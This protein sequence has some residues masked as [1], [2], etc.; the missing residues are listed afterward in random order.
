VDTLCPSRSHAAA[1]SQAPHLQVESLTVE[2]GGRVLVR[3]L[4]LEVPRGRFVAVIGPSGAGKSTLLETLAGMRPHH[5]GAITY[6]CE[7]QC[8]HA[9]CDFRSRI[10]LVFQQLHLARNAS[11]LQ[12]VLA[13]ALPRHPWWR[14]LAGFPAS[15]RS[16]AHRCLDSLG[17]GPLRYRLVRRLSGGEQQRVAIARALVQE[18]ELILADEPVSHLDTSLAERVLALLKDETRRNARTVLCVL[19]DLSL[20]DR[21]ADAVLSLTAGPRAGWQWAPGHS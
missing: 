9:P 18:P 8:L 4:N 7:R 16:Y 14:T 5:P 6:R 3:D 15:E 10:G 1:A 21:F 11:A 20:V 2:R 13:G 17:L 19:H 12:N